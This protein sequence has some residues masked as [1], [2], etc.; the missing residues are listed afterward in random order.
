MQGI[1]QLLV[2]SMASGSA[3]AFM[4]LRVGLMA[5]P[6]CAPQDPPVQADVRMK[7]TR[8]AL[9]LLGTITKEQGKRVVKGVWSGIRRSTTDTLQG[10]AT[11]GKNIVKNA[12]GSVR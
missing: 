6:Y 11:G 4:T 9:A 5:Q 12:S 7:A 8:A 10:T 3:N 1:E 2:N